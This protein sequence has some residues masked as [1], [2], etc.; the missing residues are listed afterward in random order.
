MIAFAPYFVEYGSYVRNYDG[1]LVVISPDTEI[2]SLIWTSLSRRLPQGPRAVIIN[3]PN[4]PTGVVYSAGTLAQDGGYPAGQ[5][6]RRLGTAIVLISDE[7]YRELAYDGVDVPYVTNVYDNTVICYSYSK[8][9]SLPG[10]RIGY[11]VIPDALKDS[12]EVFNAATIA[13]RVHGL[14]QR[15]VPDAASHQTLHRRAR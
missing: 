14:R 4:N 11:L 6:R 5:R 15:P 8:S 7:P 9:L 12:G 3:T 2:S 10:E 13:N 1:D